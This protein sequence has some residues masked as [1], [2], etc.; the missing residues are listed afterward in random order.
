MD[1]S[2]QVKKRISIEIIRIIAICMVI[3]NHTGENGYELFRSAESTWLWLIAIFIDV[4]VKA[5]VPLF[6]MISG[7]LLLGKEEPIKDVLL[8]RVLRYAIILVVFSFIYYVRMYIQHPEYGFSI[9]FFL[10]Y[11]YSQ[12]F[13]TPFWFLY[14]YIA[15]LLILPVLRAIV[16]GLNE[17]GYVLLVVIAVIMNLLV[18]AEFIFKLEPI[19]FSIGF[20]ETNM[21]YPVLGYGIANILSEKWFSIKCR[22]VMAIMVLLNYICSVFMNIMEYRETMGYSGE[23]IDHFMVIPAISVFYF[24]IYL[25]EKRGHKNDNKETIN[26][27]ISYVGSCTFTIYLFE[28]MLRGDIFLKIFSIDNSQVVNLLLCIPY[29]IGIIICG[30]VISTILKKIPILD[31]C[32]L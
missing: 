9:V 1:K 4:F 2:Y 29:V 23:Y 6:F 17:Y 19:Y 21:L 14:L 10:K 7:A 31:K 32:K 15:F 3:Y 27:I 30:V 22:A 25:V 8:R 28:E 13:I 11:I 18:V 26:R 24:I 12:P 16:K 20:F 5:G